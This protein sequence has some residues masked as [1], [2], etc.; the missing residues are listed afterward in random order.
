MS[1]AFLGR[2]IPRQAAWA[3]QA[4]PEPESRSKPRTTAPG[5]LLLQLLPEAPA[6]ASFHEGWEPASRTGPSFLLQGVN[7][8]SPTKS[9]L[10]HPVSVRHQ[11][12]IY[13][14]PYC[15]SRAAGITGESRKVHALNLRSFTLLVLGLTGKQQ[16]TWLTP[17]VHLKTQLPNHLISVILISI[18][19]FCES[20]SKQGPFTATGR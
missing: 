2:A 16:H 13:N 20:D 5:G 11:P 17:T 7:A 12:W 14:L 18:V 9:R 8:L 4:E 15:T 1:V 19:L 3:A 6:K 10:E